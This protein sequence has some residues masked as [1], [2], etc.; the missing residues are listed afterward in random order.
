[1]KLDQLIE[2]L[3]LLKKR[4]ERD[5]GKELDA[6]N[7][8]VR[9]SFQSGDHWRTVLAPQIEVP[10]DETTLARV[11]HSEYHRTDSLVKMEDR[12]GNPIEGAEE[13]GE[14]A[15]ILTTESGW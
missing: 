3:Q 6:G 7:L 8:S 1:M 13:K 12:H 4:L 15:I 2:E 9:V 11:E 5:Y 14:L 10:D